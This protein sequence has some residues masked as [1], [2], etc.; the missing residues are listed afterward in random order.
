MTMDDEHGKP[1]GSAELALPWLQSIEIQII[2]VQDPIVSKVIKI[3]I[4]KP[5]TERK[6]GLRWASLIS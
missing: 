2:E 1:F 6:W 3:I 5:K 4:V